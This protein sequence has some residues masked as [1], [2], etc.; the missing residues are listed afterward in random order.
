M[1]FEFGQD[2][3]TQPQPLKALELARWVR[4]QNQSFFAARAGVA[5]PLQP[6]CALNPCD[7]VFLILRR[8]GVGTRV[9]PILLPE[10]SLVG[11]R[12]WRSRFR[13]R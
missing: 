1:H 11:F 10:F 9:V 7:S 13:I 5:K 6:L 8:V 3:L 12:G 2:R 4:S